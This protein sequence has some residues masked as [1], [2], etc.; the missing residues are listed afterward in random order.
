MFSSCAGLPILVVLRV[1]RFASLVTHAKN[2]FHSRGLIFKYLPAHSFMR[3][4]S[5]A[6]VLIAFR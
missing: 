6:N 4:A 5:A 1:I 2:G 3:A